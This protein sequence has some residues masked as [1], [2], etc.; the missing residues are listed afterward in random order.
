VNRAL[1]LVLAALAGCPAAG[2]PPV[3]PDHDPRIAAT[4]IGEWRWVQLVEEDG[5]RRTEDE[6]WQ[7]VPDGTGM[8]VRGRYVRDVTVQSTDGE[9]FACNQAQ[10]YRQRAVFD[11]VVA[12]RVIRETGYRTE[13]SPCDHGFRKLGEY[14]ATV[15]EQRVVLAW[16]GGEATLLRTGPPPAAL[17]EPAWAGDRPSPLGAWTWAATW[18]DPRGARRNAAEEWTI[19]K[20]P[21]DSLNISVVRTV[22]SVDPDGEAIECAGA[23]RWTVVERVA[24]EAHPEG[25]ILRIRETAVETTPHPCRAMSPNRVLDDATVEQIGDYLVVEWRGKRRQVL[26]R[27]G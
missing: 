15:G 25:E 24:M 5:T 22:E 3:N 8:G 14:T 23:D 21:E 20:G 9:P 11:V 4:I 7:L 10:E 19:A 16:D 12:G 2:K 1:P 27:P 6:R 18:Q 26:R 17:A 13:P